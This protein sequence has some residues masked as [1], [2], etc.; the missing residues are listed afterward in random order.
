M[1]LEPLETMGGIGSE[2]RNWPP[3]SYICY[4]DHNNLALLSFL[5]IFRMRM[6]NCFIVNISFHSGCV[7]LMSK[8]IRVVALHTETSGKW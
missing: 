1:Y 4:A 3:R 2:E 7:D 8:F 6:P 5:V